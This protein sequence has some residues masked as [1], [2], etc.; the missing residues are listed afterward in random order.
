MK[1]IM[2]S[3]LTT[4]ALTGLFAPTIIQ[5]QDALTIAMVTDQGGVDDKSFNQSAW[6]GITAY[7]E[8][9]GLTE[10][11]EGYT[12][13]QSNSDS[14]YIT[15]MNSAVSAGFDLIAG[16]GFKLE[17]AID[18]IAQQYPDKQFLIVDA[19]VEQPNVASIN[20]RDNEAAFLAGVAAAK[21]TETDHLGFIGGV[22]GVIIDRFEA[23]FI[24]GAKAVNPDIEVQVEYVGSFAD[25][26]KGKQIAAAMYANDIDVIYQAA[27]DSGNG[28][29][30][31]AKDIV[32]NDPSK[33][34]WVIGVDMDQ[35]AEG[36]IEV[37]GKERQ[38]TLTSTLKEVGSAVKT[39]AETSS[40]DGF[41]AGNQVFGLKDGGVGITEGN[42]SD[43]AKAEIET[44]KE[45]IIK[46]EIEVPETPAE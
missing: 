32:S 3:L 9:N 24:E 21:T 25:A 10:G 13:I 45:K 1:K 37:D 40:K 38:L 4:T 31:E 14:D 20:F 11:L 8:E 23:G 12:Y 6:E 16:I 46:G 44:Y 26:P 33:N 36:I 42:L 35:E 18:E 41:K 17:S 19:L 2:T 28:V 5:A 22:E 30:S 29:F 34:I 39:F 43:D 27:G 7:G 15:N